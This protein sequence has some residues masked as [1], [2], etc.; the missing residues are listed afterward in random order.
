MMLQ[1]RLYFIFAVVLVLTAFGD[2]PTSLSYQG[3]LVDGGVPVTASRA[4][5]YMLFVDTGGD[6]FDVGDPMAWSQTPADHSVNHG[7]FS[8]E[9]DFSSGFAGGG[10]STI[11]DVFNSGHDL[12]LQVWVGPSGAG[13]GTCMALSPVDKITS[14]GFAFGVADKAITPQKLAD[15]SSDG[16]VLQWDGVAGE[17]KL[18]DGSG[19]GANSLQGAYEGGNTI[20]TDGTSPVVILAGDSD[21]EALYVGGSG[22]GNAIKTGGNIWMETGNLAMDDGHISV[23]DG[24]DGGSIIYAKQTGTNRAATFEVDNLMNM[25][26]A[27]YIANSGGGY[28]L[29]ST[30]GDIVIDNGSLLLDGNARIDGDI[31]VRDPSH[32]TVFYVDDAT[33]RTEVEGKLAV[34]ESGSDVFNVDG[35]SGQIWTAGEV[36]SEGTVR[37]RESGS[38][39]ANIDGSTGQIWTSG[40]VLAE[41]DFVFDHGGDNGTMTT[42]A[43]TAPRTWT[44]PDASGTVALAEAIPGSQNLASVINE[45]NVVTDGSGNESI[46]MGG[47]TIVDS[48]DNEV[49]ID[50]DLLVQGDATI[51]G[52]LTIS[53]NSLY[54]D[55]GTNTASLSVPSITATRA[56]T[57]P[58]ASGE[59]SVLGQSIDESEL[60]MTAHATAI[61]D[62]FLLTYDDATGG[63][64]WVDPTAVGSNTLA[65]LDDVNDVDY[66]GGAILVGDGIDSYRQKVLSGAITMDAGG[67]V[68]IE[69]N[70]VDE[71]HLNISNATTDGFVLSW[72]DVA[73][74]TWSP[75]TAGPQGATWHNDDGAPGVGL[76]VDD[77]YYLD[78]LGG[79]YYKKIAGTWTLQGNMFG[80]DGRTVLNGTGAPDDLSDGIDGD[81]YIDTD[82]NYLYGPKSGGAWPTPGLYLVGPAGADGIDGQTILNGAG[83]PDDLTDGIDGDFYIDTDNNY[84]YGPKSGGAWPT[85]GLYLVGPAGAD[86]QTLLSGDGA[87]GAGTGNDGDFY[88]DTTNDY[89]YGPKS[90]GVWPTP[91]LYL[92]G[93]DGIDGQTILNGAGAPDDLSDGIDGDFY[94]DTDNHYLYGPKSGGAWPTPGLYLVGPAG[95]DGQTL[96]SGDG[97][98]DAGT[99]NDG[100]FYIDTTNDYLY[101]PKAGGVWP[102]PGLYLVGQ[103]GRTL[104]N[105][106]GAPGAGTGNDGDFYID[107]TND[108]LYGPKAGGVWPTPGLYLVGQDGRTLLNGDGAPGAGLG[109]DGDFYIDTTND[110]IYGPKTSGAWGSPTS[111]VG[112]E[113]RAILSGAGAPGAGTGDNG[114]FY[115]D[116]DND[117]L[118]GP[119]TAGAW[120]AGI[121]LVGPEGPPGP[122]LVNRGEWEASA[123]YDPGDYVFAEGSSSGRSMWICESSVGPTPTE[124][125]DEVGGYWVEFEAPSG[126]SVLT[127][128]GPPDAGLGQLEDYC[129]DKTN[130]VIYG[131]KSGSGWGTGTSL[132][133]PVASVSATAPVQSSGGANPVISMDQADGSTDGYLSSTD[134]NTFN[135][136][137]DQTLSSGNIWVGNAS[138]VATGVAMSGDA[139]ITSA[140]VVTVVGI[141]GDAISSTPPADGEILKWNAGASQWQPSVDAGGDDWGSQVVQTNARLTG[142]GTAAS[143]LDIAQQ[144]ASS[145]QVLKWNGTSWAP[146]ND[147]GGAN[148][149]DDLTDVNTS[150]VTDGQVI[151]YDALSGEWLPADD[152]GGSDNQTLSVG[153][154]TPTTSIIQLTGSSNDITLQAGSNVT[155]SEAGNTITIASTDN[156]TWQPNTQAQAGYVSAGGA[157]NNMVWKTDGSGNPAWRADNVNDADSDPTNELIT[158]ATY[159]H[160]S[161]NLRI[162]EA[163]TNW[164]VDLSALDNSGTD[165]Q[166]LSFSGAASPYTLEISGGDNVTFSAGTG[167]TLNRTSTSNLTITN[168]GDTDPTNEAQTLAGSGT[169][170]IVL[171]DVSGTGGGTITFAG[172]GG[173]S[174]SRLGNTLTIDATSAGDNWGTQV[175]QTNA[176]LTGNGTAASPLDIAQQGAT[177]GQALK[178]NGTSWAPATDENTTYSAGT[179][180][181]ITGTTITNTAPHVGTDI[182][183]GTRTATTVPVTSST[184]TDATLQAATTA[185]A[186]VMTAADKTKLDGIEPG[187][188]ANQD[189]SLTGHTL[190]LSG[191]VVTVDLSGYMD[192]TDNQNLSYT[193]ATRTVNISGGTGTVLPIFNATEAGLTPLSGGGTTNFLRADGN[194]VAP[195]ASDN[196]YVNGISFN[197]GTGDLTLTREGLSSLTQNLDGRYLTGNQTITLSGDVTGS[198]TTS[199]STTI[200]NNAVNSAKIA[201]GSI[202]NADIAGATEFVDV[203]NAA[204]T[205]QFGISNAN[206]GLRFEGASGIGITFDALTNRVLVSGSG[207]GSV[208]SGN[209]YALGYYASTGSVIS[210]SNAPTAANQ[211]PYFTGGNYAFVPAP[212]TDGQALIYSSGNLA[213]GNPTPASHTHNHNDL[214][215]IQAAAAGVTHG[216]ITAAAQTIAGAKTFSSAL[217]APSYTSTVATGTAP[218]T[219]TSTTLVTNLNADLLDGQHASA[220]AT[221]GH[222]H[223][224][225]DLNTIQAAG[226]GVTHGHINTGAQTL[227]GVKSFDSFPVTPSSAPTSD[228][229]TAN[230]KYV[231]DAVT[232]ASGNYVLKSGDTMT[233]KLTLPAGTTG[234]ASLN[235]PHGAAPTTPVNGDLWTTTTSLIGRINGTT[236]TFYHNGNLATV[237]QAEAEAGTATSTRAWTAQRVNQ[238]IQALAP[239]QPSDLH[240]PVTL[241]GQDYLSLTDQQVTVGQIGLGGTHVTGTLPVSRGGTGTGTAPANGQLLI[242]NGTGYSIANISAGS[243]VSITNGAGTISISATGS[244][245]TVTSVGLSMPS[246]FTVSGSPVTGSGTL[247]ASWANQSANTVLAGPASGAAAAPT[248][249]ALVAADLP[250]GSGNYIQNQTATNQTAGFRIT[251]NGL[252]N[253]GSVGIGTVSPSYR[254]HVNSG[255]ALSLA[256]FFAHTGANSVPALA[257]GFG[258]TSKF[259]VTSSGQISVAMSHSGGDHISVRDGATMRVQDDQLLYANGTAALPAYTFIG[260][261]DNGM[262]RPTTN[263]L[264][265]STAGAERIRVNSSGNVGIGTTAPTTRLDVNG[266]VRIR[267]GSPAIGS[268]LTASDANGNATWTAGSSN[269]IQ[270]LGGI[271]TTPQQARWRLS[272]PFTVSTSTDTLTYLLCRPASWNSDAVIYGNLVDIG[273][274]TDGHGQAYYGKVDGSYGSLTGTS[275]FSGATFSAWDASGNARGGAG[276]VSISTLRTSFTD[277]N[278][279]AYGLTGIADGSSL[280]PSAVSGAN[281]MAIVGVQAELTGT[282]NNPATMPDTFR[283]A[284]LWAVDKKTGGTATSYAGYF[285]GNVNITGNLTV[286]GTSPNNHNHDAS[287]ITTGTLAVA[288]GGTGRASHT[289][290]MPILGG[291]TT[292]GAQRSVSTGTTV[293]QP[294]LYQGASANPVWGAINLGGGTNI[295][296]GTLPIARGGTNATTYSTNQF[297]WYNG[298]SIVASGYSNS[299]FASS[300]HNHGT[301]STNYITKFTNTTGSIGNSQ[302]YDNGTSVNIGTSGYSSSYYKLLVENAS[303]TKTVFGTTNPVC[304]VSN[305][306]MVGFNAYWTSGYTYWSSAYAGIITFSQEVSGGFSFNT[307]PSGTGGNAATMTSRMAITN[308]GNVGIGTTGPLSPLDVRATGGIRVTN[309]S[310]TSNYLTIQTPG[311]WHQIYTTNNL[312]IQSGGSITLTPATNLTITGIGGSGP[313]LTIDGSGNV[314][315]TTIS[316][317]TNYWTDAGSYLY[318]TGGEDVYTS[319]AFYTPSGYGVIHHG[320]TGRGGQASGWQAGPY[321][322]S[323]IW[324]ENTNGEGGGF[325]ADGDRAAIWSPGDGGWILAIYDEDRLPSATYPDV[326]VD[327]SGNL[328]P[329]A[330]NTKSVGTSSLRFNNGHFA[331][332]TLGGVTISSWPSGGGISGSGTSGRSARWTGTSTLG[333][334]AIYDNGTNIAVGTSVSSSHRIYGYQG[335]G[336][337]TIYGYNSFGGTTG[338][339][340]VAGA[341]SVS[342]TGYLGYYD[343]TNHAAVYGNSSSYFGVYG[344]GSASYAGVHGQNSSGYYARL[345]YSSYGVWSPYDIMGARFIDYNNGTYLVDPA[346]TSICNDMRANIYYDYGNTSYYADPAGSSRFNTIYSYYVHPWSNGTYDLGNTSYRWRYLWVNGIY[347]NGV[348]SSTWPSGG[349]TSYWSQSG[350]YTYPSSNSNIQIDYNGSHT[351]GIYS[352]QTKQNIVYLSN[353][354]TSAGMGT[355]YNYAGFTTG[356]TGSGYA[357]YST[358]S[359]N[360]KGCIY[361]G[362]QYSF[363]VAGWNYNDSYRGAGV[364]GA[365]YGG[366]YWG[367]LGYKNSGG[368]TYGGYF[369]SYTSGSGRPAP[370][371]G[372]Y[373]SP[374]DPGGVHTAIGAGGYGDLFG[375]HSD[376]NIYGFYSTGGRYASYDHGDR[377]VT[378]LD[379]HLHDVGE[380]DNAV[381]Y[382]NVSTDVSVQ[383]SGFGRLESG[384]RRVEFD[385]AFKK[386]LSS[387]IPVVVTVSPLGCCNGVYI[388]EI[389]DKGFTVIENNGGRSDIQFTWIAIGRRAGH[390]S[391]NLPREVVAV[392]YND[393]IYRG[394]HNDGDTRTDGEGL[395]FEG[396]ELVVGVHESLIPD[397]NFIALKDD[398]GKNMSSRSY[399]EW[400]SMFGSYGKDIGMSE[401]EYNHHIASAQPDEAFFDSY[402]NQI[403][404]EWVEEFRAEGVQMFTREEADARRK[405]AY[406]DNA[407]ARRQAEENSPVFQPSDEN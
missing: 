94:I 319:G 216:H 183:Q 126:S 392:D 234:S 328:A 80:E 279:T 311:T 209:Q 131:P 231:D 349:G 323:G 259:T 11:Q 258:T 27:V 298:S 280:T 199:I 277:H 374:Y 34:R 28:A 161:H 301:G 180:I 260:D 378:G 265:F 135:D 314:T 56:L 365:Q 377:Y 210:G 204:G 149:L 92:V 267:G 99:G 150:G 254:L 197:T 24:F 202:V 177:S 69:A 102:T 286:S 346:G 322:S 278:A 218:L 113:G 18:V 211:L 78:N 263:S 82:N 63:F 300:S 405:Q 308:T 397:P 97:A 48:D 274:V 380:E 158:A 55:S 387:D 138:D 114:D 239:V 264:G 388:S 58:D 368:T 271:G 248:F 361:N 66:T 37:V 297:L 173:A 132:I 188:G 366:S 22:G 215:S 324:L 352:Y 141:Q 270:N 395:Y 4:I 256:G 247:T 30:G 276:S 288:R 134:W 306:P 193:S 86:G 220:F 394:L 142:A 329:G 15:G 57:L 103:D 305:S 106:D 100:D 91:G 2:V 303:P 174:V 41:G 400:A 70:A 207:G 167:I 178:W 7:I 181:D 76:G 402:G 381:L 49:E 355:I 45:G 335:A 203:Q 291:T 175:A 236:R 348:Y 321:G 32:A 171:S 257:V 240:N 77:D 272:W 136:K 20:T 275:T 117:Y 104:L 25:N 384:S 42:A 326:G 200:A 372:G 130:W 90:G 281:R 201:D 16:Q 145:G 54:F 362:A 133:G 208:N 21:P 371:R 332:L 109:N 406:I 81:F 357:W 179:G 194:W 98:P 154:G 119:K 52:D 266:T 289:A 120:G 72:D 325:Y 190:G 386:V 403:P 242:G 67:V 68:S 75:G 59:I 31:I 309:P 383:T 284:A 223:N 47:G 124:P 351:Y 88:I 74:L 108:Y 79:D 140:G 206:R 330:D 235:I 3:K 13:F 345:G 283:V 96:L 176:R 71:P 19:L 155:L 241:T 221:S 327:G 65:G 341:T 320:V 225:N 8:S 116:T 196:N 398:F 222:N 23:V 12:Y 339:A 213:W 51:T 152:D 10:Y 296:N 287:H 168:S 294:L 198:G 344:Y 105:G 115:I 182:A 151:K 62:G 358:N 1:S 354:Y 170:D 342:G 85:P 205:S 307:A 110:A 360:Y 401:E 370:P 226:S 243:G 295:V 350:N 363:S 156:D 407:R 343:G 6:G 313:H 317:G 261:S 157:N 347:L 250:S 36:F 312:S 253:G 44:F 166:N 269:F 169:A 118:Y 112:P 333:N 228:Y 144:G 212:S 233:G 143:P 101:G 255:D 14:H 396:G 84:L 369:T 172:T 17:W 227:Y 139:T 390:E 338:M 316:A 379:V 127:S 299:S 26:P 137:L 123:S 195:P 290:Y 147:A 304:F 336:S 89:L 160:A 382:T 334:S 153:A 340:G 237:S 146:A 53:N 229:Q 252:F 273:T 399:S 95:A 93:A 148:V 246:Q 391:P 5:G 185:L 262:F 224:H 337:A 125:K 353:Q 375:M 232:T 356:A 38:D 302:I 214:N 87:P 315:R 128:D 192:N 159:T 359:A 61:E 230:K 245:G 292:T 83:A 189:L 251:G 318:P 163:G 43:L 285:D 244:G 40:D 9:L 217:S 186:G 249:R 64:T 60:A 331:N 111:L 268:V 162:T 129:I 121:S 219:V 191:S 367:T 164:D 364:F 389:D 393:K 50:A 73:G 33:G 293:G 376:G 187:A 29:Q 46:D 107:T 238:A 165:N 122:G 310:S 39:V 184:G 404:P 35:A 385:G 373:D 282:I